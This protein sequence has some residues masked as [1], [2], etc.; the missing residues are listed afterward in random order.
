MRK[1]S[2]LFTTFILLSSLF[3]TVTVNAQERKGPPPGGD[4]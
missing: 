3:I 4:H 2:V 1:N